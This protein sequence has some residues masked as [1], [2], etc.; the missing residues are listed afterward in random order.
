M[1]KFERELT[2]QEK[3]DMLDL[4]FM[5]DEEYYEKVKS[6]MTEEQFQKFLIECPEFLEDMENARQESALKKQKKQKQ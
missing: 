3:K 1:E 4:L 6:S 5:D 2:V